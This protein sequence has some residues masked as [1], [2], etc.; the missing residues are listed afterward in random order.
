MSKI[1]DLRAGWA[2]SICLLVWAVPALPAEEGAGEDDYRVVSMDQ[3]PA[4]K[5][6]AGAKA[7][8]WDGIIGE[9]NYDKLTGSDKR[10]RKAELAEEFDADLLDR[11]R[12]RDWFGASEDCAV[13]GRLPDHEEL[14][15]I[16]ETECMES[17]SAVCSAVYWTSEKK[18]DMALGVNFLNGHVVA[19]EL[20]SF[21]YFRCAGTKP[22]GKQA[23]ARPAKAKSTKKKAV[24]PSAGIVDL[25]RNYRPLPDG[26]R[27][28][29]QLNIMITGAGGSAGAVSWEVRKKGPGLYSAAA[30]VPAGE[31][32]IR[33][34]FSVNAGN[35]TVAPVN[36]R[37]KAAFKAITEPDIADGD[38]R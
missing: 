11:E 36:A 8:D 17:T 20:E 35:K 28:E 15:K 33:F 32:E 34:V 26:P 18:G 23:E 24:D 3:D 2:M 21:A 16:W 13:K 12:L 9:N 14:L 6:A 25:V 22:A 30:A 1:T 37:A 4:E 31:S 38:M 27:L 5:R 10:I 7:D 19:K 29:E